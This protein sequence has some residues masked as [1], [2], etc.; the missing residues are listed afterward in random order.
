[1]RA[2]RSCLPIALLASLVCAAPL[3][4]GEPDAGPLAIQLLGTWSLPA[5]YF[6]AVDGMVGDEA[7]ADGDLAAL[8]MHPDWRVRT[9]AAIVLLR[10]TDPDL[11]AWVWQARPIPDRAG[12]RAR[13][14]FEAMLRDGA[15]AAIVERILRG[16]EPMAVRAGL[17]GTLA[18]R[19][20]W[21][22]D[23]VGLLGVLDEP[24]MRA[25][26]ADA[27]RFSEPGAAIQGLALALSDPSPA[28]RAAAAR[29]AGWRE[30]G[31]NLTE[32]L[33]ATLADPAEEPRA[34]AAR[35]LGWLGVARAQAPLQ[36]LLGDASAEVRLHA[37]RSLDRIDPLAVP[38]LPELDDLMAD[39]DPRVA[40]VARRIARAR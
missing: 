19:A 5:G 31:A 9:Q 17:A 20:D 13:F 25:A 12:R 26:V 10:R 22:L 32:E 3:A 40:R 7:V 27:L 4:A 16:D 29:S 38:R 8:A 30:D 37:L 18:G 2:P 35:A 14:P 36:G 33:V 39:L 28:V 15:D 1:M 21:G 11:H 34:M 23:Q 6:A 24:E